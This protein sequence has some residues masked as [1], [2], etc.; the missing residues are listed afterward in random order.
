MSCPMLVLVN[1]CC[2]LL[3]SFIW[4]LI[5]YVCLNKGDSANAKFLN[6]LIPFSYAAFSLP[7]P[8]TEL[9]PTVVVITLCCGVAL[10]SC[11]CYVSSAWGG[12]DGFQLDAGL[13]LLICLEKGYCVAIWWMI[14][15]LKFCLL[16]FSAF[17]GKSTLACSLGREL[18]SRGKLSY[19]LD[20]D[21]LR[22][23]LNKNLGFSAEDRAENI[24]RVGKFPWGSGFLE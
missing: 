6:H 1:P 13:L 7:L 14:F 4:R 3:W 15:S 12:G 20:G 22:H 19:V 9:T 24:R 18:H 21:N 23:G 11:L 2:V 17:A 8:F 10:S 16:W 5:L